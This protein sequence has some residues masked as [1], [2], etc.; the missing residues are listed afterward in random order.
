[1]EQIKIVDQ[2]FLEWLRPEG[3]EYLQGVIKEHGTI[4]AVW[5]ES[6]IPHCVHFQEG[7]QIRNWM[8]D[9]PEFKDMEDWQNHWFDENWAE[10]AER[11]L[12][13][14]GNQKNQS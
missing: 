2:R 9:Q 8:R 13:G 11:N 5:N 1:M 12:N 10:F 6:G 7:M 3:I 4:L 14:T